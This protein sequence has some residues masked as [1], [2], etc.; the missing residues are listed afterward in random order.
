MRIVPSVFLGLSLAALPALGDTRSEHLSALMDAA[1]VT[2]AFDAARDMV[3][4]QARSD[5]DRGMASL[6]TQLD[7][8]PEVVAQ[9]RQAYGE[10]IDEVTAAAMHRDEMAVIWG[11]AYG[12][13]FSD[14]EISQLLAFY[15]SPLGQKAVA[16]SRSAMPK[17]M[18]KMQA[19]L[20]PRLQPAIQRYTGKVQKIIAECHCERPSQ[21]SEK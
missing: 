17:V 6:L 15:Q 9:L 1:G 18:E 16:A 3:R 7:A 21:P 13:S 8:G 10:F 4:Q 5:A 20:N 12:A 11:E 19:D 14:E 2:Q